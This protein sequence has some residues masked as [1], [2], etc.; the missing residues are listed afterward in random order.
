[1]RKP[2]R[3]RLGYTFRIRPPDDVYVNEPYLSIRWDGVHHH[4]YSEWRAFANSA[5][6][7]TGMLKG[8]TAISDNRAA[9]YL[10]DAR[11]V[12]V[13]VHG[14]QKWIKEIWMPQAVRAGLQRLAF[15]T[16]PTGLGRVTVEEVVELV[17][18]HGL[19]SRTFD[20]M[21]AAGQWVS[22]GPATR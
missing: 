5:E 13:I 14:D 15:V 12:K 11:K 8:L 1:L 6:L 9:A 21:E 3:R 17:D 7:R 19:Q 10:C 18:D 16:A 20:S 22:A 4:V 2:P